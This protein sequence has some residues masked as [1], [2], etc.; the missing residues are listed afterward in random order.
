V[1]G[2]RGNTVGAASGVLL[3]GVVPNILEL[4]NAPNYRIDAIHGGVILFA[5]TLARVIG[6]EASAE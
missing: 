1:Q 4:E 3:P 6:G 5:L 2:G